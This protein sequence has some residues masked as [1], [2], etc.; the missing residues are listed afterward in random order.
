M[1]QSRVDILVI[2]SGVGGLCAA[3]RLA[4]AGRA[5]R[6]VEKLPFLGGRFSTRSLKGFQVTTGA[7]MVPFGERSAFHETFSLLGVPLRVREPRG[8]FR[9]RL[10]HGE[11]EPPAEGGGG[12]LGML[13]FALS[14]TARARKIFEH[15]KQALGLWDPADTRSFAQWLTPLAPEKEV[16]NLF[17]GFCAA[18]IGTSL[19]E[20]P[21]GEFFRFLKA[22]GRNNRYG[23][24]ENGNIELME[25][26]ASALREKGS[27]VDTGTACREIIVERGRV[28][29]ARIVKDSV[30][31]RVEAD[32]VISN[33]GPEMTVR[34]TGEEHFEPDYLSRL[35]EHPFV[36][37][38]FHVCLRSREPLDPFPGIFNFG[39][40]RRLVFLETPTLTCPEL[41]P[42]GWHLTTTFSVPQD[43]HSP[44]KRKK[45]LQ[46]IFLDL[47]ENFPA[48]DREAKPIIMT[49]HHG[50][51][52]AMRRWPG[53]P[54]PTE[55]PVENLHNV[56]D[57]CM[58]PGTVGIEA[59]ALSAKQV[60]REIGSV[61]Q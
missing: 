40:T 55:T 34:L 16:H 25:A 28:R 7:I 48:F 45:T 43:S 39:N 13:E 22:M 56:G 29:G 18:F 17:Q 21:A 30:E 11:Y 61:M 53:H 27:Q 1:K 20:V 24:A 52:P 58:P 36:T 26:L 14:D 5:V 19:H 57:G 33:I 2:G 12:L 59:C 3:A 8:G 41:A 60:V 15:F 9:Y 51:W 54:V 49:A 10:R 6:V 32:H 47:R 23:I 4:A 31:E 42:D 35:R 46:E 44:L 50:Q 37:P 38:V